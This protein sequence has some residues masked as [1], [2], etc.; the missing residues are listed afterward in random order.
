MK[1]LHEFDWPN[2][3]QNL[4]TQGYAHIPSVFTKKECSTI[5]NLYDSDGLFRKTVNMEEKGY[6]KGEYRYFDGAVQPTLVTHFRE[7]LYSGLLASANQIARTLKLDYDY[8]KTWD[9]FSDFCKEHGQT[10]N[11]CVLLHYEQGDYNEP[12]DDTYGKVFFPYQAV[13]LLSDKFIGGDFT[14]TTDSEKTNIPLS[15]VGDTIIFS[16]K[17]LPMKKEGTS[18]IVMS[19][20]LHGVEPINLGRRDTMGTILHHMEPSK[21]KI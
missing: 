2:I 10:E 17:Y 4:N 8:P 13:T 1:K 6:G 11:A 19:R 20:V 7:T 9:L 16:S 14:I 15:Q 18:E 12:H 3:E 21:P 5:L